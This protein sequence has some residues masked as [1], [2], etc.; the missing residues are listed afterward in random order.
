M[1]GLTEIFLSLGK[2]H[3]TV[4]QKESGQG[5]RIYGLKS[6]QIQIC[7]TALKSFVDSRITVTHEITTG[8]WEAKYIQSKCIHTLEMEGCTV[9][10]PVF[11]TMSQQA[12]VNIVL[13]GRLKSAKEAADKIKDLCSRLV[14]QSFDLNCKTKYVSLWLKRWEE[15]KM[16]QV[17]NDSDLLIDVQRKHQSG[18]NQVVQFTIVGLNSTTMSKVKND[19]IARENGS[20]NQLPMLDVTLTGPKFDTILNNLEEYEQ[21]L[22]QTYH[23]SVIVEFDCMSNSVQLITTHKLAS[24]LS[25]IRQELIEFIDSKSFAGHKS[26]TKE[27]VFK[28]KV[29]MSLLSSRMKAFEREAAAISVGVQHD[30]SH[31][32]QL[33]IKLSGKEREIKVMEQKMDSA[34]KGLTVTIKNSQLVLDGRNQSII[35]T[36]SF[37]TFC[38]QLLKDL[39]VECIYHSSIGEHVLRQVLLKSKPGHIL[40]LQIVVGQLCDEEVDAIVVP[41]RTKDETMRKLS[42][43]QPPTTIG[44]VICTDSGAAFSS[45]KALHV[46]LPKSCVQVEEQVDF[47]TACSKAL[48]YASSNNFGTLSIPALG[49][50]DVHDI[51]STLCANTLLYCVDKHCLNGNKTTLHTIRIVITKDLNDIFISCFDKYTFKATQVCEAG[52]GAG[53]QE[54][55]EMSPSRYEWYWED[56]KKNF[57]L[58]PPTISDRLTQAKLTDPDK[59]CIISFDSKAYIIDLSAMT[60]RNVTSGFTRKVLCK[61]VPTV[62]EVNEGNACAALGAHPTTEQKVQWYYRDDRRRFTPYFQSD[63][64]NLENMYQKVSSTKYLRIQT[65]WYKFDFQSM[66]QVNIS[67]MHQRDIKR[68]VITTKPPSGSSQEVKSDTRSSQCVV[69]LRGPE[70]NLEKA[71]QMIEQKLESLV[72]CKTV[73]LPTTAT[74]S[75][76]Q[77]IFSI[78]RRHS[79]S[80]SIREHID[81]KSK[82]TGVK[83][84]QKLSQVIRIEGA[85]H[86]VDKAVTEVQS[87]IIEFHTSQSSPAL[88]TLQSSQ[89]PPEWE[90]QTSTSQLFDLEKYS[91]EWIRVTSLFRET[92]PDADI[93]H[94]KR[95]QNKRLWERYSQQKEW[96]HEKNAGVVNEKELWHGSK[97]STADNIYASEE[98]FDMRYSSEGLWGQANYFAEKASYSNKYALSS[99]GGTKE[100][101]LA[102]VLTGES[103]ESRPDPSLRMPPE[104]PTQSS[105]VQ[106]K[107]LRYDSVT[108]TTCNC[109]VYMTYAND[110]AYPAY[111]VSYLPTPSSRDAFFRRVPPIPQSRSARLSSLLSAMRANSGFTQ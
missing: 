104:K 71:K 109:R 57:T 52:S 90:T 105:N 95:I 16:E 93:L 77:K 54:S 12:K 85:E 55:T 102:K 29:V 72:A 69:N 33:V 100:L 89:Y 101:L 4:I 82:V 2:D 74:A 84:Q 63:S 106:L 8:Y 86:M 50:R 20:K 51:S 19:I 103:F 83:S 5:V 26:I 66:K 58:Y 15:M 73:P 45:D 48:D 31:S 3:C 10:F 75:L 108:G 6:E 59:K 99:T 35:C 34:V 43:P 110:K 18:V 7:W 98:G 94:V 64:T 91:H 80:S 47:V 76:K 111:L 46:L 42:V 78:A 14:V 21:K 28:D 97:K 44:E 39:H 13:N 17:Q 41:A 56:D 88:S 1:S 22:K 9:Q 24:A 11:T 87:E 30:Q 62:T 37:K 81:D 67:T 40:T 65:R 68:D 70:G 32:G 36:D 79:V 25:M 92:M 38:L 107:Q 49:V 23:E 96:M 27:L 60:Q 53:K 61:E